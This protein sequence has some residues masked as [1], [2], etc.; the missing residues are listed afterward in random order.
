MDRRHVITHSDLKWIGAK[1]AIFCFKV[2]FLN[3]PEQ[4]GNGRKTSLN[5]S[6]LWAESQSHSTT[7]GQSVG[8]PVPQSVSQSVS[9]P[10]SPSWRRAP[11]WTHDQILVVVRQSYLATDRQSVGR[12]VRPSWH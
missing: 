12:S 10:V 11:S 7:D 8:Q 2:L 3:L 1:V 9:Q 6:E 4:L 5:L